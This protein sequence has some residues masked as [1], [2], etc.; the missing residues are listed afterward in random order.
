MQPS[1][2]HLNRAPTLVSHTHYCVMGDVS[3]DS[4]AAIAPGVV[5]Q[6]S[7]GS[8]IVIAA[9][10]CLA[11]GVCIQ[12]RSGMLTIGSGA[13]LGA[14]VLVV[15]SG[16]VGENAC[17]SAGSTLINPQ[18]SSEALVPPGSRTGSFATAQSPWKQSPWKTGFE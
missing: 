10:A 4:T 6:A 12:S 17:I 8:R 16:E 18:L 3:V 5:L 14:N 15:G 7:P 11:G 2:P 9:R 1:N 13:N